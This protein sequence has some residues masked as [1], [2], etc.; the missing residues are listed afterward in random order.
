MSLPLLII[1]PNSTMLIVNDAPT[2]GSMPSVT[3]IAGTTESDKKTEVKTYLINP[4]NNLTALKDI[5]VNRIRICVRPAAPVVPPA[6]PPAP[7]LAECAIIVVSPAEQIEIEKTATNKFYT[8]YTTSDGGKTRDINSAI[9]SKGSVT[10]F[11]NSFTDLP[12]KKSDELD[13]CI[14]AATSPVASSSFLKPDNT[15]V[16]YRFY[17]P[18]FPR[19]LPL[20]PG[21]F[22]NMFYPSRRTVVVSPPVSPYYSPV[23]PVYSPISP[24]LLPPALSL[25]SP[26]SN[27][28]DRPSI[29][30]SSP[31][32]SSPRGT[33]PKMPRSP[34]GRRGGYYEKYLKYKNKYVE[35]KA[36]LGK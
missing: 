21:L 5:D 22:A 1:G 23:S 31:R 9:T 35:L 27:V 25:V 30:N 7:P 18:A 2:A 10:A 20:I 14:K 24:F 32:S 15:T 16:E 4:A 19:I 8:T 6:A 26:R 36:A 3:P 34:R 28:F 13:K 33:S 12:T 11:F 17:R 29:L